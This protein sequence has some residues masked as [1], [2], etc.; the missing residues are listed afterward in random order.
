[1]TSFTTKVKL[2]DF[3]KPTKMNQEIESLQSLKR[4]LK[5]KKLPQAEKDI[6]RGLINVRME[7]L[8]EKVEEAIEK[9]GYSGTKTTLK[10]IKDWEEVL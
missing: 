2:K 1:M 9:K 10:E 8:K 7:E 3:Y 5:G 4:W 6:L